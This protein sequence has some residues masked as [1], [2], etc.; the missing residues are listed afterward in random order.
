MKHSFVQ[1]ILS[2]DE[3]MESAYIKEYYIWHPLR[4]LILWDKIMYNSITYETEDD[5]DDDD[6][7]QMCGSIIVHAHS[8]LPLHEWGNV[9][10]ES[11]IVIQVGAD[12]FTPL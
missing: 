11:V 3:L 10:G 4:K 5:N 1:Q 8:G 12:A 2:T 6:D 9:G 7:D